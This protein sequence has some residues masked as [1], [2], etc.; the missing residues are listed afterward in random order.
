[1][2]GNAAVGYTP[3][4]TTTDDDADNENENENSEV[5][6]TT[7]IAN[8][9]PLITDINLDIQQGMKILIRGPN[10]AGEL[11]IHSIVTG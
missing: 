3:R 10:G 11:K 7:A 8:A 1:M 6:A 2:R 4:T 9:T 5:A